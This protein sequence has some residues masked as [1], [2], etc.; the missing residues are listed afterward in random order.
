MSRALFFGFLLPLLALAQ[1]NNQPSALPPAGYNGGNDNPSDPSDAGAQGATK[2]AFTLSSGALAAI[3]V[4]A[5][6]V[7]IGGSMSHIYLAH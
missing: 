4:V 5:V 1:S 7:V 6:V 2:G 3:I